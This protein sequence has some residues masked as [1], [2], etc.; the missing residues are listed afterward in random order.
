MAFCIVSLRSLEVARRL[1]TAQR[2][3]QRYLDGCD[4][5]F[6]YCI[7]PVDTREKVDGPHWHARM[8][9]Y[10]GE[11]PATGSA[12]GCC[13]SWLVRHG[14]AKSETPIVIEQGIE[15]HRPSRITTQAK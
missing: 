3:A 12:A 8:Q 1:Q 14:L 4:A 5:K 10:S 6:F 15:I 2:E 7:A 9:F 13:I 11:D